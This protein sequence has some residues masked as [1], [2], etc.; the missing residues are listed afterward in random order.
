MSGKLSYD[1]SNH[2]FFPVPLL[3]NNNNNNNLYFPSAT[4]ARLRRMIITVSANVEIYD[5]F[6]YFVHAGAGRG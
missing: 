4:K 5:E 1:Y 2:N 3:N 6:T